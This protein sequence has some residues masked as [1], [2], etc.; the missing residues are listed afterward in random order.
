MKIAYCIKSL[1]VAGG[2]ER[3]ITAKANYLVEQGHEVA[4]ITTDTMG[5]KPFF[6]LH[7]SIQQ[8]DLGVN[9]DCIDTS[10]RLKKYSALYRY[11]R[12][13]KQLLTQCL[14]ELRPDVVIST[15]LLQ[16][17]PFLPSIKDGSIKITESHG[18]VGKT[19]SA[20]RF[21]ATNYLRRF[22]SW[23]AERSF[24]HT[25]ARYTRTV[26]LTHEDAVLWGDRL[27][28]VEVIYNIMPITSERVA[29]LQ[30]SAVSLSLASRMRRT[31]E[32]LWIY[33]RW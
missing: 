16:T 20:Y 10:S 19:V 8:I 3:V 18:L 33:G 21:P 15:G 2:M 6:P 4:I 31:S 26:L 25:S 29:P 32:I 27:K 17:S 7:L 12:R 24:A 23:W 11:K 1:H 5:R 13:H 30:L 22:L 28:R 14:R 9:Y